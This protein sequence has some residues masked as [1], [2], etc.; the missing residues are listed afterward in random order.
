MGHHRAGQTL[1]LSHSARTVLAM[2]A[3]ISCV[4][5]PTPSA[6]IADNIVF[7][8][9]GLQVHAPRMLGRLLCT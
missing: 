1:A 8:S 3:A 6:S 7:L 2:A 5:L 9:A 4:G